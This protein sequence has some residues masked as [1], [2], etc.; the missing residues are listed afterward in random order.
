MNRS[1]L[2]RELVKN[3]PKLNGTGGKPHYLINY[4]EIIVNCVK[5]P[6]QYCEVVVGGGG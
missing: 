3:V 1:I 4:Y 5:T 2:I 6:A